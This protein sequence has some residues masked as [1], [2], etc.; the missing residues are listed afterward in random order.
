[1]NRDELAIKIPRALSSVGMDHARHI[2]LGKYSKGMLQRVGIAQ[3]ILHD[4]ELLILDEPMSGLDPIGRKEIRELIIS[5]AQQ[6]RTLFFSSHV[7]PDVEAICD[8]VAVIDRGQIR[9]CGPISSFLNQTGDM[10]FEIIV[11]DQG[12][13]HELITQAAL[14]IEG[15]SSRMDWGRI[16]G[17]RLR[18]VISGESCAEQ[19]LRLFV[20]EASAR[21]LS[22]SPIRSNLEDLFSKSV[23]QTKG[24]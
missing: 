7:I 19:L 11:R 22:Y 6:G 2:E 10:R 24:V 14:Q 15:L 4:P 20:N 9:A 3:A 16:P 8:Q 5:L 17:E 18:I 23:S 13:I 21:I 1:M 12:K